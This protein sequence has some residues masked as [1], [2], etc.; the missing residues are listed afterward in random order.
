ME[1]PPAL[2]LSRK[3]HLFWGSTLL[4]ADVA[5]F[6]VRVDGAGGP[7][8][9]AVTRGSVLHT[10]AFSGL[11]SQQAPSDEPTASQGGRWADPSLSRHDSLHS[12]CMLTK[13]G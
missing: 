3:G 8:L 5:S 12:A 13:H 4:R 2:G 6:G 11:L 1:L 9:L 10:L 7:F